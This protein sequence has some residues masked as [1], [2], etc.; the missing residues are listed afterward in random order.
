MIA[1]WLAVYGFNALYLALIRVYHQPASH[2]KTPPDINQWPSVTVQLPVYNERYVIGRLLNAVVELD[3][4]PDCVEIQVLDDSDDITSGIIAAF[5]HQKRLAGVNIHHIQRHTRIGYKGGALS[6]GM[7]IARGD[8][9]AIFDADFIPAPDTLKKII[10]HF[11]GEPSIGCIQA[12]WGHVNPATSLLT[13][14]QA[15]GIDG[16]FLVQQE[17]RSREHLFLNFNG[18]AGVWRRACIQNAGGWQGDTLTEDLDLSYRAQLRGWRILYLPDITIPGELPVLI[19]AFKRQQ[20][21]WA[22]GS[23]Q[24]AR[25]LL[26]HLWRSRQPLRIKLTSTIHLTNYMVHPLI[27]LNLVLTLPVLLSRSPML[28]LMPLFSI[29]ALGPILMYWIAMGNSGKSRAARLPTLVMLLVTGMGLSLNNT[30]AVLEALLGIRSS[31]LRTPKFNIHGSNPSF[32]RKEYQVPVDRMTLIEILLAFYA[33]IVLVFAFH[34]DAW[35]FIF[36]LP[37]YIASF[38]YV[39]GLGLYQSIQSHSFQNTKFARSMSFL[40]P[41]SSP[42][43]VPENPAER[44]PGD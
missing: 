15:A 6:H 19:T 44:L 16:H 43:Q 35:R 11:Y 1:V 10:P 39:A 28:D 26:I 5:V 36:W 9:I 14:S 24:T 25:K 31:F 32:L 2:P 38:G 27:L 21:R 18:T 12:R 42:S 29:A 23:I 22:K 8:Y 20:F 33:L 41:V 30:L 37:V 13:R 40:N 4:P 7:T 17:T 34:L 3:Y